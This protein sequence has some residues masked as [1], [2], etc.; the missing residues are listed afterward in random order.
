MYNSY[1]PSPTT[2]MIDGYS[3]DLTRLLYQGA[4]SQGSPS[5]ND[6]YFGESSGSIGRVH[7]K[8]GGT[9]CSLDSLISQ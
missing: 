2:V 5:T 9:G 4:L 1:S 8:I 6:Q 3:T 7:F